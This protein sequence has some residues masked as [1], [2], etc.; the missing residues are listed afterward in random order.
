MANAKL[1]SANGQRT[2][3]AQPQI[4][5]IAIVSVELHV[6][7]LIAGARTAPAE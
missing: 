1:A 5:R 2:S 6:D 3:I 4:S 7:I